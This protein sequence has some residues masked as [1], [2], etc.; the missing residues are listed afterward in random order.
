ML[1]KMKT[2]IR[3]SNEFSPN[4]HNQIVCILCRSKYMDEQTQLRR[5]TMKKYTPEGWEKRMKQAMEMRA[6]YIADFYMET[7]RLL[8]W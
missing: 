2:C 8:T 5:R 1:P 6:E 4:T 7:G 3:C